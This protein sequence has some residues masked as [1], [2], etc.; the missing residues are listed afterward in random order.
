M[1]KQKSHNG[2]LKR[3]RLTKSGK[4]KL[5]R[6]FGRHLR[7]HKSRGLIRSY[8]KPR[9]A[10]PSEEKRLAPLLGVA[11]TRRRRVTRRRNRAAEAAAS[12]ASE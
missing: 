8:R 7:S 9:Y 12:S 2:L 1:S 3:C 6:A 10:G 5:R 11:Y 4:I